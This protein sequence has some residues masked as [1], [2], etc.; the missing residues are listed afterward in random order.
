MNKIKELQVM[1]IATISLALGGCDEKV[2]T[3]D[4]YIAHKKERKEVLSKCKDNPGTLKNTPNCRN[5]DSAEQD[6]ELEASRK[7]VAK[8]LKKPLL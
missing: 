5:A 3:V 6:I 4:W 8:A 7:E 1:A 2:Q